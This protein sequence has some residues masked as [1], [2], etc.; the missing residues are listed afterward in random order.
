MQMITHSSSVRAF[1]EVLEKRT[2]LAAGALDNS[3]DGDG[4]LSLNL[5]S[6]LTITAQDVAVQS[7]GKTIIVGNAKSTNGMQSSVAARVN[8]DGTLDRTFGPGQHGF[9]LVDFNSQFRSF[10]TS[11]AIQ[12]DGKIVMG[13]TAQVGSKVNFAVARFLPDGTFDGSFAGNGRRTI[14]LNGGANDVALQAVADPT[15]GNLIT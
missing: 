6:D 13:G 5:R 8:I 11:V 7:D 1:A 3:F 15:S 2:L 10:G 14:D 9:V 12:S 4:G